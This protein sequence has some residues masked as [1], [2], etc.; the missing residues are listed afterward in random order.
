MKK[1]IL[2]ALNANGG[3]TKVQLLTHVMPYLKGSKYPRPTLSSNL[4]IMYKSGMIRRKGRRKS[5]VYYSDE[6]PLLVVQEV[7]RLPDIAIPEPVDMD[8]NLPLV[9]TPDFE[10]MFE[11]IKQ[12]PC[13]VPVVHPATAPTSEAIVP[14]I[15]LDAG[16]E[17]GPK[18]PLTRSVIQLDDYRD[19]IKKMVE[20]IF[21]RS[22]YPLSAK[23]VLYR[24]PV[25]MNDGSTFCIGNVFK[26]VNDV[27]DVMY[28]ESDVKIPF[29]DR[30]KKKKTYHEAPQFSI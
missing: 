30:Q 29:P 10:A 14:E 18:M 16:P 6:S 25:S 24:L 1:R 13:S 20:R 9:H 4:S 12:I 2:D 26:L 23:Q 3:M 8:E 22:K 5:Y 19:N 28:E 21:R 11:H 27:V 15:E 7:S 17:S